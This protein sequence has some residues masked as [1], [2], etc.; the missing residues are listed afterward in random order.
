[1]HKLAFLM[2][3]LASSPAWS[4]KLICADCRDPE[5]HPMDFGNFAYNQVFGSQAWLSPSQGNR[6]EV[7]NL[8]GQWAMVDLNF[9]LQESGLTINMGFLSFSVIT[10][11]GSI[12]I[13]VQ[14]ASGVVITYEVF[15]GT[16]DLQVGVLTN[17]PPTP[18]TPQVQISAEDIEIFVSNYEPYVAPRDFMIYWNLST[19]E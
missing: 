11:T 13:K 1:M 6:I 5:L 2:L 10:P 14:N 12:E 9:I 3:L 15:T 17:E 18:T 7:R 8:Q 19:S 16:P 4:V